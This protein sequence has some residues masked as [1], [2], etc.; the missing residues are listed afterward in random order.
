LIVNCALEEHLLTYL[1]TSRPW[2]VPE[3]SR[4][5]CPEGI[6]LV[7]SGIES[8]SSW[9]WWCS[10]STHISAQTTWPILYT[11]TTTMIHH[12]IGSARDRHQLLC[13]TYEDEIWRQLSLW[14]GQS[15]EKFA[16]GSSSRRQSTLL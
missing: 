13:S 6:A 7:A 3:R 1:L 14:P 4:A 16:S 12:A 11:P 9:H 8:S 5:S 10:P 2:L 15:C